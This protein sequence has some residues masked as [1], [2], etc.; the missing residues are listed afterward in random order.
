MLKPPLP[1]T[2]TFL[3]LT[4][5]AAPFMTPLSR[6][7]FAFGAV[8]VWS[9]QTAELEKSRTYRAVLLAGA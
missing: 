7:A 1:M 2:K 5:F 8:C 3:T 6:Y 4:G 9:R